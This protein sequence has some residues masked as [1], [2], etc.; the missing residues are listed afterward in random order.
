VYT[1]SP[2]P[3]HLFLPWGPAHS[4]PA[5]IAHVLARSSP[6]SL[7]SNTMHFFAVLT[8]LASVAC[9]ANHTVQVAPGGAL[10]FCQPSVTASKY[11]YV[12]AA[13]GIHRPRAPT[14]RGA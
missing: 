11:V 9:A 3:A 4:S 8:A 7:H 2:T 1:T 13:D 5:E 14:T 6:H 12:P 10:M